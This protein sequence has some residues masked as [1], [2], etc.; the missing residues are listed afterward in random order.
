MVVAHPQ[1]ADFGVFIANEAKPHITQAFVEKSSKSLQVKIELQSCASSDD[2]PQ[3]PLS[4]NA[5]QLF[6]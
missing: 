5:R 4:H 6:Q 3:I 2:P 1:R